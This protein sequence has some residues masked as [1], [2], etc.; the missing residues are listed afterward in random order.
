MYQYTCLPFGLSSAPWAFTKLLKPVVAYLR[1]RGIR[2]IIYLDDMLIIGSDRASLIQDFQFVKSLLESLGFLDGS[3]M[4]FLG[5]IVNS[6][7]LSVS[8][9]KDKLESIIQLCTDAL[10]KVNV[11]IRE[12]A[13]ILGKFAWATLAIH[14]AQ[15]H[16]RALQSFYI[17]SPWNSAV[18][19]ECLP[20]RIP[21]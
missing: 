9:P 7:H 3:Q 17:T 8:L 16:Y 4:E 20:D 10:S 15:A 21:I 2:L 19:D 1:K 5:L 14:F 13:V 12:I 11:S 6:L 18:D